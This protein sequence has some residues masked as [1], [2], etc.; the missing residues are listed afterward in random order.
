[1][2]KVLFLK[3]RYSKYYLKLTNNYFLIVICVVFLLLSLSSLIYLCFLI[4]FLIY[5][6]KKDKF[7]FLFSVG[8]IFLISFVYF[9]LEYRKEYVDDKVAGKVIAVEDTQVVVKSN[10][11]KVLVFN[12]NNYNL[13]PGNLV[14]V[15][16]EH[17]KL[18]E[19]RIKGAF[20]YKEY[21]WHKQIDG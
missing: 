18:D 6:F 11:K 14:E 21:L 16:G 1:M 9:S 19:A 8:L 15:Q 13:T 5:L 12:Y 17:V 4:I 10:G 3:I 7:L 20:N 2:L